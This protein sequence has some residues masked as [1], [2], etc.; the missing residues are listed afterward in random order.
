M[1]GIVV[2][3]TSWTSGNEYPHH[4]GWVSAVCSERSYALNKKSSYAL[5]KKRKK[6]GRRGRCRMA[7]SKREQSRKGSVPAQRGSAARTEAPQTDRDAA[8]GPT[9][10]GR[11]EFCTEGCKGV[12]RNT[13]FV[14]LLRVDHRVLVK[15]FM[16]THDFVEHHAGEAIIGAA[17]SDGPG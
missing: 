9:A 5:N 8:E 14:S 15:S 6:E 10:S 11:T 12:V 4:I 17:Q 3:K 13:L 1:T 16:D 2:L 7:G